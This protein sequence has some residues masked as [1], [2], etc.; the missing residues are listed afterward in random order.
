MVATRTGS[1]RPPVI[2]KA[3]A[4]S[5]GHCL[6][7]AAAY[8][9]LEQGG[10][11]T[12]AGVAAGIAL[13]VLLPDMTSFGGVAPI[14]IYTASEDSVSSISGLGRWPK[15]ASR[16]HF[17]ENHDRGIPIGVERVVVPA[18]AGA[19]LSALAAHGTMTF[20]QV[21][22]PA[23]ELAR[24][25]FA[26]HFTGEKSF[27]ELGERLEMWPST[28]EIFAPGGRHLRFGDLVVQPALARTFE[29]M[30]EAE[31]AAAGRGRPGA[32]AAARERFYTGDI[33]REIADFVQGS[34]GFLSIEDMADFED[35]NEPCVSGSF[36]DYE[37][38]ACGPWCQGPTLIEAL[39]IV[40]D[41]DLSGLGHNSTNYIHLLSEALNMAFSDRDAFIGDPDFV[42]VPITGLTSASFAA[43]R[44]D[45]ID[46]ARACGRMP[47]AGDPWS[48]EGRS[49]P[50]DYAYRLPA[51]VEGV[52]EP[53]TSYVCV[54]D[55]WGNAFS[56]T[57]SDGVGGA[58]VIPSLGLA[59]SSRGTQSWL[60]ERHPSSLEP[61]KRP[62]LTPNP[63]MAFKGGKLFMPFGTPGGDAQPQTMLQ[64]FLN[65]AVFGM[66]AQEAVEA[67]RFQ[68]TNFPNS[69]WPHVYEP[70]ALKL[71]GSIGGEVGAAL[72]R[73][74]HA[75]GWLEQYSAGTGAGCMITVDHE[76][77]TLTAGA[78]F[79]RESYAIGR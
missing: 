27:A 38:F 69:F 28:A 7:S 74:G 56:A 76:Q 53:D 79:R 5:T 2:A 44:R 73:R 10:N 42:D 34:G 23:L 26:M 77:G 37:V 52:I 40:G 62:R 50:A 39:N 22:T 51:P 35:R 32:I 54:V 67:P 8:R 4:T 18:A 59:P 58:P 33:G 11:A 17:I 21:V 25:G 9:I 36:E 13:N 14:M 64:L 70:G 3:H 65:V 24:D 63:A 19:W 75:I 47:A 71:E 31:R 16:E 45:A 48:H 15:A 46:T 68:S 1:S 30:V 66:N 49:A 43:K 55:R 29:R 78:D 72:E 57:P 6:A 20:E 61:W 41:D 60:D 12:D